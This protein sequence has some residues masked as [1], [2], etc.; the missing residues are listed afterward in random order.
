MRFI[1]SSFLLLSSIS[2]Y[3]EDIMTDFI[4]EVIFETLKGKLP[5]ASDPKVYGQIAYDISM[6]K[7]TRIVDQFFEGLKPESIKNDI[8]QSSMFFIFKQIA[9]IV[10]VYAETALGVYSIVETYVNDWQDWAAQNRLT[11]FKEDVLSKTTIKELDNAWDKYVNGDFG[12]LGVEDRMRGLTGPNAKQLMGKMKEGYEM[13][14]KEI[15]AQERRKS[16]Y[17]KML[18]AKIALEKELDDIKTQAE[19]QTKEITLMMKNKKIP[20]TKENFIKYL[21]DKNLYAQLKRDYEKELETKV[22]NG[23]KISTGDERTDAIISVVAIQKQ[24]NSN[25]FTVPDYSPLIREFGLNADRLLT[26]N[27]NASEYISMKNLIYNSASSLASSCNTSSSE[28]EEKKAMYKKCQEA[29]SK[30]SSETNQIEQNLNQYGEKLKSDLNALI[31]KE[32][33]IKMEWGSVKDE[34]Y[35]KLKNEFF[36]TSQGKLLDKYN[37]TMYSIEIKNN[38]EED[39][40]MW[41][42][43]SWETKK[44]PDIKQME[45]F[46]DSILSIAAAYETLTAVAED[47]LKI[48]KSKL[49]E[50]DKVYNDNLSKYEKLY[51]KNLFLAQYFDIKKY[52]FKPQS[53]LISQMYKRI[54]ESCGD[55]STNF[56]SESCINKWK[57]YSKT[58]REI[59]EKWNR[60]I[61]NNNRFIA[62]FTPVLN[63]IKEKFKVKIKNAVADGNKQNFEKFYINAK[64]R[65]DMASCALESLEEYRGNFPYKDKAISGKCFMTL[66]EHK[67]ALSELEKIAA[68]YA[69]EDFYSRRDYIYAKI[70]EMYKAKNDIPLKIVSKEANQIIT[71]ANRISYEFSD[72]SKLSRENFNTLISSYRTAVSRIE[73]IE[74]NLKSYACHSSTVEENKKSIESYPWIISKE[75]EK[76]CLTPSLWNTSFNNNY[77]YS[78]NES[79]VKKLYDDMKQAYE[80]RSVSRVLSLIDPNWSS[81][82]GDGVSD[83]QEHLNSIFRMFNEIKFNISSL[84][85][86]Y[87][88]GIYSVTYNLEMISKIYSKNINRIENSSVTEKVKIE[89]GKAKIIK[90]ENGNYWLVK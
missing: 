44:D 63:E 39:Y 28:P 34:L 58:A 90:T 2:T 24:S 49:D 46:R 19:K 42:D 56:L 51:S 59:G 53:E 33:G 37:M 85:I 18:Y 82:D 14:R 26:N 20:L 72:F 76:Y 22:K 8:K 61:D 40:D 1:L 73:E 29:Y 12:G 7:S 83:L 17:T 88:D 45:K 21:N 70:A 60:E 65:I 67:K 27:I 16:L 89:N 5:S 50:I 15:E 62:Q 64:P 78:D 35:E 52:D 25:S 69:V 30:F 13:R 84:N 71:D 68:D 48:Y 81:P 32:Y 77:N 6:G 79:L 66:S 43:V 36:S 87:Q 10:G 9:P 80:S 3:A 38:Y 11:E 23:E 55:F 57:K 41:V 74:N 47:K 54:S 31:M 4:K 75:I 86:I